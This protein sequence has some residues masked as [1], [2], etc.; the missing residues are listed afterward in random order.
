MVIM[1]CAAN[2]VCITLNDAEIVMMDLEHQIIG[3]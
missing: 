2:T 1:I 3:W